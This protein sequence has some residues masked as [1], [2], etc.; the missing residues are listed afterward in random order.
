MT[1]VDSGPE[2]SPWPVKGVY[3]INVVNKAHEYRT[4]THGPAS[5]GQRIWGGAISLT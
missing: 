5:G 1:D 3:E 2:H 4:P